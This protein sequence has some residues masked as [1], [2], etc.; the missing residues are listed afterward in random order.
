MSAT[1]EAPST[2][3]TEP[4]Q[5]V[6]FLVGDLVLGL[7]IHQV[8]EINRHLEIT[9]VPHAQSS[10]RGVINLRGEVVSVIDLPRVLGLGDAEIS[11][12]SRNVII[13]HNGELI[14]LMVD[15]VADILSIQRSEICPAPAN[16]KG[17]EGKFFKGVYT[18]ETQIVV[19]LD[20]E[21]SLAE[22]R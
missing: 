13:H 11:G 3:E 7:P 6:S 16:V 18:T 8:Q 1:L 12:N 10:I 21:E 20:V 5:Y 17:V 15:D 22:S 9:Y 4:I 19:I 14:G 2:T